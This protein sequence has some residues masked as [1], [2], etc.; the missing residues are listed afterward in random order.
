MRHDA[1]LTLRLP[2]TLLAALDRRADREGVPRGEIARRA[3]ADGLGVSDHAKG[4]RALA[5]EVARLRK[6][7]EGS[8]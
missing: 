4:L 7:V 1:A 3:I 6:A 5:R 8:K 2:T